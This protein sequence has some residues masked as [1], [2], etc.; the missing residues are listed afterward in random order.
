MRFEDLIKKDFEIKDGK[1]Y[2]RNGSY[3]G[4]YIQRAAWS[5]DKYIISGDYS[6]SDYSITTAQWSNNWYLYKGYSEVCRLYHRGG[7]NWTSY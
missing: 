3:T 2:E 7:E 4:F 5:N 6:A 1:F